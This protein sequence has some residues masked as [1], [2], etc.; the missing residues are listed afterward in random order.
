MKDRY[1]GR[2]I[3]AAKV[4]ELLADYANSHRTGRRKASMWSCY[5]EYTTADDLVPLPA[6]EAKLLGF[7]GW[8][9]DQRERSQRHVAGNSLPQ[10]ISAVRTTQRDILGEA[11][12]TSPMI[13]L[14]VES[15]KKWEEEKY[16]V[17]DKRVGIPAEVIH[18]V[19]DL[20]MRSEDACTIRDSAMMVFAYAFNGL[21]DS[22]VASLRAC[23]VRIGDDDATAT[24]RVVKGRRASSEL[25]VKYSRVPGQEGSP[26]DILQRW[27]TRH[28][29]RHS[30]F[31]ALPRDP[32]D[33]PEQQLLHCM[34]RCLAAVACHPPQGCKYGAHS[35]R[36]GA[37]TTQVLLGIPFEARMARFGWGP[38]SDA[39]SRLYFD[40][41]IRLTP[42]AVWL[43]GTTN[44]PWE[45]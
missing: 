39:M 24:L 40:R 26:V 38:H 44:S 11:P 19:Y 8:L 33:W 2:G 15:Y 35:L 3:G 18:A 20:G 27:R 17:K 10:Y 16:P 37:H 31:F 5:I 34:E 25:P 22:S 43:F 7:I 30:R 41:T 21:R 4:A 42:A 32:E 45:C 28:A 14:A 29:G 1:S 12:I 36:I 9:K 13:A 23:D 6:T